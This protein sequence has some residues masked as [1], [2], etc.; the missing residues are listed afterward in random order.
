MHIGFCF[1]FDG[2]DRS[3]RSRVAESALMPILQALLSGPPVGRYTVTDVPPTD[4]TGRHLFFTGG[5]LASLVPEHDI[6][7]LPASMSASRQG[8]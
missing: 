3:A 5:L 8:A 7:F 4:A 2:A 1:I 6:P